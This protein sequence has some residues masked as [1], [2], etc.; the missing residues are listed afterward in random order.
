[1]R[2]ERES[3]PTR[4]DS[5]STE[6]E[7]CPSK[8]QRCLRWKIKTK[9][10]S[11][12]SKLED[13]IRFRWFLCTYWMNSI[14]KQSLWMMYSVFEE[15]GFELKFVDCQCFKQVHTSTKDISDVHYSLLNARGIDM[16]TNEEPSSIILDI[17]Y[18]NDWWLIIHSSVPRV[19]PIP[20][21]SYGLLPLYYLMISYYDCLGGLYLIIMYLHLTL[22]M[23]IPSLCCSSCGCRDVHALEVG[24]LKS[25]DLD[26]LESPIQ[27][28]NY[29]SL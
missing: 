12:L 24:R 26:R 15:A 20:V 5:S 18:S 27:H 2:N 19:A 29:R 10:M 23:Y 22:C 7:S 6:T 11:C 21:Y 14:W 9:L 25:Q 3:K 28:R 4:F 13:P 8:L 16:Y 1:M 17:E